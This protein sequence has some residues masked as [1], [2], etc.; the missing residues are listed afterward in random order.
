MNGI[1][2][3]PVP[4]NGVIHCDVGDTKPSSCFFCASS[5]PDLRECLDCAGVS[6]CSPAHL[7]LHRPNQTC[8]PFKVEHGHPLKGRILVATRDVQPFELVV[9]D[10][11]A[12][13][14]PYESNPTIVCVV[15]LRII[16][17]EDKESRCSKCHLPLCADCLNSAG[18]AGG[19]GGRISIHEPECN[20][21]SRAESDERKNFAEYCGVILPLRM[22]ALREKNPPFWERILALESHTKARIDRIEPDTLIRCKDLLMVTRFNILCSI[23]YLELLL[24]HS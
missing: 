11:S 8:L 19:G 17:E 13:Y 3:P 24:P 20:V 15:C 22:I 10:N 4:S 2:S 9:E 6:Y 23:P 5:G 18:E 14:G 1:T 16:Q 21:F 12:A 7:A